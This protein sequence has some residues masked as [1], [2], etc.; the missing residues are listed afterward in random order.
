MEYIIAF[1]GI[2]AFI[3]YYSYY[4]VETH[5]YEE[6]S[7]DGHYDKLPRKSKKSQKNA[8]KAADS[9]L[10]ISQETKE[11]RKRIINSE[12]TCIIKNVKEIIL[13]SFKEGKDLVNVQIQNEGKL[14]LTSDVQ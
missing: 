9:N 11:K 14:I 13:T 8:K 2:L 10:S 6:H 5:D 3:I 7:E 4:R 12:E 1:F